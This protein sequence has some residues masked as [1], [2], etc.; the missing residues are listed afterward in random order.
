MTLGKGDA[1]VSTVYPNSPAERG[2]LRVGDVLLAVN[3][4]PLNP[5][6]FS[7]QAESDA[8]QPSLDRYLVNRGSREVRLAFGRVP[9]SQLF[10]MATVS[11][12]SWHLTSSSH[13]E[14]YVPNT[15][16]PYLSGLVLESSTGG[17]LVRRVIPRTPA[18]EAGVREGDLVVAVDGQEIYG[19]DPNLLSR[20]EGLDYRANL[21]ITL[22]RS[23]DREVLQLELRSAT[24][25]LELFAVGP[26]VDPVLLAAE[27][28]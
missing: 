27:K 8:G 9:W 20:A 12:G 26:E 3:G 23:P 5:Y 7:P 11:D 19:G 25:I 17:F 16:H 4:L 21:Q 15:L 24:E 22:S 13:P 28:Q 18:A 6:S 1:I 10:A 2:G 14:L